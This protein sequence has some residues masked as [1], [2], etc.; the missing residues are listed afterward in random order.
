MGKKARQKIIDEDAAL[1]SARKQVAG[2]LPPLPFRAEAD[3]HC[4]TPAEAFADVAPVLD[5]IAAAR[6]KTR[7]T[8]RI[9]DG[10]YCA[11]AVKRHLGKLGFACVENEP[12]DFYSVDIAAKYAA[13]GFDVFLTNPPYSNDHI[14]RLLGLLSEAVRVRPFPI[15]LLMPNFVAGK[16]YFARLAAGPFALCRFLYPWQRYM[17]WAPAGRR[18]TDPASARGSS[19]GSSQPADPSKPLRRKQ[20]HASYL[21]TRTSPFVSFWY[22]VL[23]PVE[24]HAGSTR[25]QWEALRP[26]LKIAVTDNAR[27]LPS[28]VRPMFE[29]A[30]PE[31]QLSGKKRGDRDAQEDGAVKR[32]RT[33]AAAESSCGGVRRT[34]SVA[35]GKEPR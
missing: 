20:S 23:P 10:F 3:D 7:E 13:G 6:G 35:E 14:P 28:A 25:Q 34:D 21:G 8:L 17:Y 22:V 26:R 12:V 24:P 29:A 2:S 31:A 15:L 33:T 9:W 19:S 5:A 30:K 16:Q 18:W 27:S 32:R 1:L 11:G 4:E